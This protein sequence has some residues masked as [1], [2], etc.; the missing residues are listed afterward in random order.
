MKIDTFK[1]IKEI[2]AHRAVDDINITFSNGETLVLR[3]NDNE[4]IVY[5]EEGYIDVYNGGN[6]KYYSID[7][8]VS[9][10]KYAPKTAKID[11]VNI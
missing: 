5:L 2:L 6:N 8:I 1:Y 3:K 10:E 11:F 7:Q 4:I 9:I